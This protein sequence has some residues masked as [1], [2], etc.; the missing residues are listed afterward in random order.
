MS[1]DGSLADW[2]RDWRLA[3]CEHNVSSIDRELCCA[4]CLR[5]RIL[6]SDW[7]DWA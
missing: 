3:E 5:D 7:L 1:G 6:A 2:I 4:P